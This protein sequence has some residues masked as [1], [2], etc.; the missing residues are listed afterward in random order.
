AGG[1][2]GEGKAPDLIFARM[3]STSL[4]HRT[5]PPRAFY[6]KHGFVGNRSNDSRVSALVCC[7]NTEQGST[8]VER[9]HAVHRARSRFTKK[10]TRPTSMNRFGEFLIRDSEEPGLDGDRGQRGQD[11]ERGVVRRHHRR[12]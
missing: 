7:R 10:R 1:F 5:R 8:S 6:A 2:E 11:D 12:G 9:L 3:R 4:N